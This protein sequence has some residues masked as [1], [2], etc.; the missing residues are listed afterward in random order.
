MSSANWFIIEWVLVVANVAGALHS[1]VKGEPK[2][3]MF[4]GLGAVLSF[5]GLWSWAV[6]P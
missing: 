1:S 5:A 3:A 6:T 2:M 4:C